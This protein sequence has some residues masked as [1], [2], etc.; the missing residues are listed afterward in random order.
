MSAMAQWRRVKRISELQHRSIKV[1]RYEKQ[2]EE[3]LK[4][5]EQ[6]FRDC[7]RPNIYVI[8]VLER[9]KRVELKKYL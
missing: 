8:R 4:A 3:R 5:N 6:N 9:R 7:K 2:R 1:T